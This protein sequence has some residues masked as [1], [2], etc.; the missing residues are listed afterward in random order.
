MTPAKIL[1][2]DDES[3]IC[4]GCRLALSPPAYTVESRLD[5]HGGLEALRSGD[6]DLVLL[7]MKLPDMEGMEI[8][9][10]IRREKP[11]T[12]VIVM[13]GYFT[14]QNA[15]E[16]MKSGAVDYL[17]K[18][19]TDDSILIS[20]ERALEK[21]QLIEE[22]RFLRKE[23]F[24]RYS[25]DQIVGESPPILDVF[26]KIKKV[27]PEDTTVLLCGESGTGKELFARAIHTHSRRAARQFV[28]VDCSTLSPNLLESELFGHVKG[29]FTGAA[30]DKTG[31]FEA[32]H[33][34]TLFLDDIA[35]LSM[36]I[37][38]KLL[39]VLEA[40]EYKPVGA[41]RIKKTNI[42]IVAASNKDLKAMT[43]E[44]TF[45]EDLFYRIN[46]FPVFLP[47]LRER[48]EDVPV[49]AYHFL[50]HFSKKTGKKLDGF[51][52]D[53]ME[54]LVSYSW[55]GNIRQLKNVIERLVIMADNPVVDSFDLL[56][57]RPM[58]ST[59][60]EDAVP[61]TLDELK[62]YKE[63]I[64]KENY[65]E[66]EKAFLLKALKQSD[67]NISQAAE[68]VGMQRSN[69]SA[70]MKKHHLTGNTAKD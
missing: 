16:A 34:G 62:E 25:F 61:N 7:D 44:G 4:Q 38:A 31:I 28:A 30:E 41:T 24:D 36:E 65:L 22:N 33:D 11:D 14:V 63:Q 8:L 12:S 40:R 50:R 37:Q 57:A 32:A 69:F 47:P 15:V 1:I 52:D 3:V 59:L 19:F 35:N 68:K 58:K 9:K 48:K 53:A 23:L 20:V 39:R 5:G 17:T 60:K 54:T 2:I 55:P 51:A 45:R 10:I 26:N 13:T 46:V 49:L 27:A 42:R 29:A 43:K 66:T 70:L 18:P 64:L 56:E 67:G 21:K 6:F